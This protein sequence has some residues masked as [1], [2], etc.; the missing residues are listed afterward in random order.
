MRWHFALKPFFLLSPES[1]LYIRQAPIS[2]LLALAAGC[3]FAG[4][5][6]NCLSK[7]RDLEERWRFNNLA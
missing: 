7:S 6:R 1:G 2:R 4:D 5:K 3:E